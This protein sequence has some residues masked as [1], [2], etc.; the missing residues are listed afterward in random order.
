[1]RIG[2][3]LASLICF[4]MPALA[5]GYPFFEAGPAA[6]DID[7]GGAGKAVSFVVTTTGSITDLNMSLE[8]TDQWRSDIDIYLTHDGVTVHVFDATSDS[9]GK[10]DA[11]FD[12]ES[13]GGFAPKTGSAIGS[14][15]PDN[16]LSAF[17]GMELSGTW[18][19]T[20]IDNILAGDGDDLVSWSI[21][22]TATPEPGSLALVA[23]GAGLLILRRR[24][25][26]ASA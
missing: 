23:L 2:V 14:F 26:R 24:R 5:E 16:P 19:A 17:D 18:T 22:G 20:F 6:N 9:L 1:M 15:R 3:I 10:F 12:D 8:T 25:R 13:A 21:S 4:A 7:V 11:T